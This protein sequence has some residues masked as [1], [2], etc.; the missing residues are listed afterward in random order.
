MRAQ[1]RKIDNKSGKIF[2][3]KRSGMNVNFKV[4]YI[5]IPVA[6]VIILALGIIGLISAGFVSSLNIAVA[7]ILAAA[8]LSLGHFTSELVKATDFLSRTEVRPRFMFETVLASTR[9]KTFG[10]NI[11]NIG[12]ETAV[13]VT[14]TAYQIVDGVFSKNLPKTVRPSTAQDIQV[15]IPYYYSIAEM[16]LKEKVRV[17]VDYKDI[18]DRPC[19]TQ[20]HD[21]AFEERFV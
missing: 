11:Q 9:S 12:R 2:L 6:V 14:V 1:N 5:T 4:V 10:F 7:L 19:A 20:F 17:C 15:N 8:T 16:G 13:D 3:E 18:Q 21:F